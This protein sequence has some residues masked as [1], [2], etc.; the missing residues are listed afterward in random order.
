MHWS[1]VFHAPIHRSIVHHSRQEEEAMRIEETAREALNTSQEA[2]RIAGEALSKPSRTANDVED[3]RRRF[4]RI[5]YIVCDI[6]KW[7]IFLMIIFTVEDHLEQW[8]TVELPYDIV[9]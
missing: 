6:V 1:N 8:C 5:L 7:D 9:Y 2:R 4:V 3:L